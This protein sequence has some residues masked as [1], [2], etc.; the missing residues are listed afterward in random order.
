M[1][2]IEGITAFRLSFTVSALLQ[3]LPKLTQ[4]RLGTFRARG[5]LFV[6]LQVFS[7]IRIVPAQFAFFP[8]Q[9][10]PLRF[11]VSALLL[12][13]YPLCLDWNKST[14]HETVAC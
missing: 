5:H 3:T 10:Q 2:R 7:S 8:A 1:G 12:I 11:A 6:G 14:V 4:F 13:V 9:I